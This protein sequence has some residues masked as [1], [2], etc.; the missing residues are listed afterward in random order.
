MTGRGVRPDPDNNEAGAAFVRAWNIDGTRRARS[1][2]ITVFLVVRNVEALDAGDSF[3]KRGGGSGAG[4]AEGDGDGDCGELY[5]A[6][7][8]VG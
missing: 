5:D 4:D 3:F 6:N 7:P 8:A 2:S 1:A